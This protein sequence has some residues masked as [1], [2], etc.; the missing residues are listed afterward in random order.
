MATGKQML[1]AV[2]DALCEQPDRKELPISVFDAYDLFKLTAD[3]L[4]EA[5]L[6][7]PRAESICADLLQA[8]L[9]QLSEWL[10]V[11]V[12]SQK[13]QKNLIPG[14]GIRRT[15]GIW[16]NGENVTP[17]SLIEELRAMRGYGAR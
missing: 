11:K 6:D 13:G 4:V 3:D 16:A 2:R 7:R 14:E 10:G 17:E 8:S 5:G 15:A 1:K 12:F 9:A